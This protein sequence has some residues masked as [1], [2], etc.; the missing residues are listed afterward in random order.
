MV[1]NRARPD[2]RTP[3]L[4]RTAKVPQWRRVTEIFS[5]SATGIGA[6][7]WPVPYSL[8]TRWEGRSID[9]NKHACEQVILAYVPEDARAATECDNMLSL[10]NSEYPRA[11]SKAAGFHVGRL[12]DSVMAGARNHIG[13]LSAMLCFR[14]TSGVKR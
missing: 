11:T 6:D 1:F 5:D 9:R 7:S 4:A 12:E 3:S 8:Y 10:A 14:M 2:A 13:F